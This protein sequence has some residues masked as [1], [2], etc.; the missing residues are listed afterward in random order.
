MSTRTMA[1][2]ATAL[3]LAGWA[4]APDAAETWRIQTALPTAHPVHRATERWAQDVARMTGGRLRI[5]VLPGGAV[6]PPTDLIDAVGQG[7]LDGMATSSVYF[8]GRDPAFALLGDLVGSYQD[9][10]VALAFCEYGGGKELYRE[11]YAAYGAYTIGCPNSGVESLVSSRPIRRIEDFKGVKIRAPEGMAATLFRKMGAS[12]V[13]L[14]PTEVFTAIDKKVVDGADYSSCAVNHSS[15]FH[16]IAKYPILHFH[17]L[18]VYEVTVNK[19]KWDKLPD[20]IKAI[21]EMSVRDLAVRINLED[22]IAERAA[23]VADRAAGVEP[24]VWPPEELAAMRT[25]AAEIWAEFAKGS[26]MAR[27]VFEA[28]KAFLEK[29]GLLR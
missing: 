23:I 11:L 16:E 20:D 9:W 8:T 22:M 12:P 24:I 26:P 10:T 27:K 17:S 3:V 5:E 14:P 15:G 18:P 19:A 1:I 29:L 21:L 13:A 6:V 28:H 4:G 25:L 2:A 7:I